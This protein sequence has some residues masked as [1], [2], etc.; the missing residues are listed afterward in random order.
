VES[1]KVL[2][3][4]GFLFVCLFV[5]LFVVVFYRKNKNK[6]FC[7]DFAVCALACTYL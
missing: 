5:C 6:E 4:D 2:Q 1:L 3:I 7:L